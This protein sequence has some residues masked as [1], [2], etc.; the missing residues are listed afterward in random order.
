MASGFVSGPLFDGRLLG[1]AALGVRSF[2]GTDLNQAPGGSSLGGWERSSAVVKL[3]LPPSDGF[4]VSLSGRISRVE[5]TQP[6]VSALDY[7]E[8]NCGGIEPASGAWS[9]FCGDVPVDRHFDVSSGIPDSRNDVLQWGV[10]M[11]TPWLG[12]ELTSQTSWYRGETDLYRDFDVSS[13]GETF[14]VC[15]IGIDCTGSAVPRP[16]DRL[17]RANEVFRQKPSSEEWNQELRWLGHV[18]DSV[19]WMVGAVAYW[20]TLHDRTLLGVARGD[21]GANQQLASFLPAT[22]LLMG[23]LALQNLAIVV[24]PNASQ[25]TQARDIEDDRTLAAF[26]YVDYRVTARLGVRTELR[27]TRHRVRV[28]NRVANYQPGFG[29]SLPSEEFDDITPRFSVEYSASDALRG[30]VSAAKGSQAG[31]IN[32]VPGLL[33]NEQTFDPEYNWT[34]EVG[35]RYVDVSKQRSLSVTYFYVEQYDTQLLG[36]SDTPGVSNLITRNVDG[37]RVEWSGGLRGCSMVT[38]ASDRSG[39]CI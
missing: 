39:V 20:T 7:R 14:G 10:V 24:D 35:G 34:Y 21:L 19:D 6:G 12:G 33:A 37:S 1:R 32:A 2:D 8:Y 3:A 13:A 28:D 9:Y 27:A 38:L 5:S 16:V 29:D 23:P 22:P 30:Y 36:F 18:G 17:L 26:G 31:G 4:N 15:T 11:S 25:I